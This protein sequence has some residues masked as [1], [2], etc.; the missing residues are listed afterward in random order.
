MNHYALAIA[1]STLSIASATRCVLVGP[2]WM[3]FGAAAVGAAAVVVI[4]FSVAS[5]IVPRA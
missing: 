5:L 3:K 4:A 1:Y 2:R